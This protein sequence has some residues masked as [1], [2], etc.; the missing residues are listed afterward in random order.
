MPANYSACLSCC[1]VLLQREFNSTAEGAEAVRQ[2]QI[3]AFINDYAT[4]QF[5]TQVS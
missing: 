3:S 2:G 4:V 1:Y 5:A